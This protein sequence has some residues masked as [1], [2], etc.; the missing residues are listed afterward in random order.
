[1]FLSGWILMLPPV[2]SNKSAD[3]F[4]INL[5]APYSQ[6]EQYLAF[7]TAKECSDERIHLY[8]VGR[9]YLDNEHAEWKKLL[10]ELGAK[11]PDAF[12]AWLKELR[13]LEKRI[14]ALPKSS[15][16]WS[17]QD[18]RIMKEYLDFLKR[19]SVVDDRIRKEFMQRT[20]AM[21]AAALARLEARC[22]PSEVVFSSQP[23]R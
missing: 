7:D 18:W 20:E 17:E 22:V 6:W 10:D 23:K 11:Y 9:K 4:E 12:D 16:N 5:Q 13:S 14:E 21:Q 2:I 19:P 15:E 1:M 8:N 3:K